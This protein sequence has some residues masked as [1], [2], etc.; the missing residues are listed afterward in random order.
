[1]ILKYCNT[2]ES[3]LKRAGGIFCAAIALMT[4]GVALAADE[5]G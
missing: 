5:K 3:S 4:G 1:M 2:L